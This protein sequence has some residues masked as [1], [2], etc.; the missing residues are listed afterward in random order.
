VSCKSKLPVLD[1]T[2]A[3]AANLLLNCFGHIRFFGT[4]GLKQNQARAAS[5]V[6]LHENMGKCR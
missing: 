5:R 6:L 1:W 2:A 4:F 3:E